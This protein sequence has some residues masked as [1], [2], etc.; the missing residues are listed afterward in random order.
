M[1]HA[2]LALLLTAALSCAASA[3]GPIERTIRLTVPRPIAAQTAPAVLM[4]E[5]FE[6]V[7][8]ERM[9]LEVLGPPQGKSKAR[10]VLAVS[11]LVGSGDRGG[12][13]TMDLV[14]PLNERAARLLAKRSEVTITL[15][16]RRGRH[17]LRWKRAYLTAA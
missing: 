14:V 5:G 1:K 15:R 17:P 2:T 8:G 13:E 4:L 7:S 12:I 11:G 10:Q 6:F 9:T 16:L 3:E